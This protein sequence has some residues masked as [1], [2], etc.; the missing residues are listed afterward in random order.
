M[1]QNISGGFH[2]SDLENSDNLFYT[3]QYD[4]RW[5]A[6]RLRDDGRFVSAMNQINKKWKISE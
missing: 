2:Q 6:Q 4:M 1:W 5:A 3:W